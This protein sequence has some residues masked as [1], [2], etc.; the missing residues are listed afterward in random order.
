MKTPFRVFWKACVRF[1]PPSA[2]SDTCSQHTNVVKVD[3]RCS[4]AGLELPTAEPKLSFQKS[5]PTKVGLF[6]RS[7]RTSRVSSVRDDL[8]STLGRGAPGVVLSNRTSP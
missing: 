6:G 3:V 1:P 2:A 4:K 5:M 7:D 8:L